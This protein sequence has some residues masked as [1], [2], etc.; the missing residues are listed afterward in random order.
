MFHSRHVVRAG[1]VYSSTVE[2]S[3]H[4][5]QHH[6][7]KLQRPLF[8]KGELPDRTLNLRSLTQCCITPRRL[9][10]RPLHRIRLT[11]LSSLLRHCRSNRHSRRPAVHLTLLTSKSVCLSSSWGKAADVFV[12]SFALRCTF[13]TCPVTRAECTHLP[14]A[15]TLL[16]RRVK[17]T[18]YRLRYF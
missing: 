8:H 2:P 11:R 10:R 13:T 18:N 3:Q 1:Y 7:H 14:G 17:T 15:Y 9:P 4:N 12:K 5:Q 6:R 16:C